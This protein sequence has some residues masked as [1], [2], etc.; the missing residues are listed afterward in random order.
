METELI[1]LFQNL[2][3]AGA[4]GLVGYFLIR[5]V[6]APLVRYFVNKR[7]GVSTDIERKV[8]KNAKLVESIKTNHLEEINRRLSVLDENDKR[9]EGTLIR[10]GEDIAWLK[11]KVNNK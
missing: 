4:I 7:N 6:L 8:D 9:I 10:H 5:D 2:P 11:A 3:L 1:Q